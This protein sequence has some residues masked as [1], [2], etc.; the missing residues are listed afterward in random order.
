MMFNQNE[1]V[2]QRPG[3]RSRC[4]PAHSGFESVNESMPGKKKKKTKL[5]NGVPLACEIPHTIHI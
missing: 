2:R 1:P 4:V 5:K 3:R